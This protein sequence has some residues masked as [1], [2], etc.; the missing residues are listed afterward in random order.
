MSIDLS[1]TEELLDS[2][3]FIVDHPLYDDSPRVMLSATL[4]VSS[5]QFAAAARALCSGGLLLG[6]SATLR[7][8][9]EALVRSLWVLHRAT[10]AQIDRLSADL[11][12]ES[13]QASKNIP[14][15]NEMLSELEKMPHLKNMFK[16][17][18]EF[19]SSS[20]LP[21]NSFVHSG[22]HAIHWT[23]H[24]AP[25]Q[26]LDTIFR[27]SNGLALLAYMGLGILTGRPSVQSELILASSS[28]S[29]ILPNLR[30]ST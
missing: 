30:A 7:S 12:L 14:Q 24:G 11:N 19:K 6:A 5:L 20:W 23:K 3:A 21:L 17:L 26:L 22:I 28:F 1:R 25:P 27:S 15:T 13:Q 10:E 2:L 9:F 4:T 16:P 8:Q 29:S 18:N